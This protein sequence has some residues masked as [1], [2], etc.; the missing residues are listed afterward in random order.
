MFW[1]VIMIV[2]VAL[3]IIML[4]AAIY[5]R[6]KYNIKPNYRVL[7]IIGITWI[8]LGIATKNIAFSAAGIV[9]MIVGLTKKKEWDQEQSWKDLPPPG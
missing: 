1:P 2:I 9:M 4:G 6:K 7:F 8:P 3:I 5:M